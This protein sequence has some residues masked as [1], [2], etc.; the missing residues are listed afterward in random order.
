MLRSYIANVLRDWQ[1]GNYEAAL[2]RANE[3]LTQYEPKID[4]VKHEGRFSARDNFGF[5]QLTEHTCKLLIAGNQRNSISR[6][7][8]WKPL[9]NSEL[10]NL[11]N[12]RYLIF[13][14]RVLQWKRNENPD[15]SIIQAIQHDLLDARTNRLIEKGFSRKMTTEESRKRLTRLIKYVDAVP[16]CWPVRRKLFML[17]FLQARM[18]HRHLDWQAAKEGWESVLSHFHPQ[19]E[20]WEMGEK[21]F[22]L[23]YE[24]NLA[25]FSSTIVGLEMGQDREK[26]LKRCQ[27]INAKL[28]DLRPDSMEELDHAYWFHKMKIRFDEHRD[29][30]VSFDFWWTKSS[31]RHSLQRKFSLHSW[32]NKEAAARRNEQ[33]HSKIVPELKP[34]SFVIRLQ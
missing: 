28:E 14:N 1:Q 31:V 33:S 9:H 16:A 18:V 19:V 25:L 20:S 15:S 32:A 6:W 29:G 34:V 13:R 2:R 12:R 8:T 26:L 22:T 23:Q 11:F 24:Y 10:E 17:Q 5:G 21:K 7:L 3:F 30:P 4:K 27:D